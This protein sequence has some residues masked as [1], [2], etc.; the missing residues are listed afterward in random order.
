MVNFFAST[1]SCLAT[2]FYI[3]ISFPS[4]KT[5]MP[6]Y[7][8]VA[9]VAHNLLVDQDNAGLIV[10][11]ENVYKSA[12]IHCQYYKDNPESIISFK[13]NL[14]LSPSLTTAGSHF[15]GPGA[16][17][18]WA[19][20]QSNLFGSSCF[21]CNAIF[22]WCMMELS[23][24]GLGPPKPRSWESEVS[25]SAWRCNLQILRWVFCFFVV[26]IYTCCAASSG[27]SS[28]GKNVTSRKMATTTL[29][30]YALDGALLPNIRGLLLQCDNVK[31]S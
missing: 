7:N 2:L 24:C 17:W 25:P 15:P 14:C 20:F 9:F 30:K 8:S 21:K 1:Q 4:Q 26:V 13:T 19:G 31:C 28:P 3:Y 5:H 6:H 29:G 22:T 12:Q 16:V 11:W 27:S 23:C 10:R 18:I